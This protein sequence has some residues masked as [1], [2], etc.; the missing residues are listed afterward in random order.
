MPEPPSAQP[1]LTERI[2]DGRRRPMLVWRRPEPV[3]TIS[4]GPLGGGLGLRSW[5]INAT[6]GASYARLDPADHLSQLARDL[7][8]TGDGV[9]LLTAVD[10][11]QAVTAAD[12]GV[13]V[14]ATV[15]LGHPTW[16]AAPDGDLRQLAPGT[17]NLVA[18]LPVSLTDAGLVNA[19]AT[20]TEAKVQ[21]LVEAGIAATGTASDALCI[22]CPPAGAGSIDPDAC[23]AGPR[24]R[25][26][27]R[28]ARAVHAAVAGG[29][30]A[31][32]SGG[33]RG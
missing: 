9:G 5:V 2:E 3:R 22:A 27:A 17:V 11:S 24:S 23:F 21:A 1:T 15:G 28:L 8:L 10:V 4:C 19:V 31:W 30:V 18:W 29:V 14:T 16:A 26:G 33:T 6:V 32:T 7:D 25:W 12:G 13:T 20:A